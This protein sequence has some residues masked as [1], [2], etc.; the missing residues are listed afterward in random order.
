MLKL[1]LSSTVIALGLVGPAMARERIRIS[2]D[3][4][5]VT[6]DLA[7]N[8]PAKSLA[9]MLPLTIEMSDHLRQEKTGNLP[10]ALPELARQR[11]FS[12]GTLGLW[13]SDHLVIY[14]RSGRVPAPGIIVLGQVTGDV[15]I[16]DRPG[17]IAVRVERTD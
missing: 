6:A 4:G 15:S 13:S 2:S 3:W 9:Q 7:D 16:F 10:S 1:L 8:E 12:V 11:D 17:P 5:E 14:Y